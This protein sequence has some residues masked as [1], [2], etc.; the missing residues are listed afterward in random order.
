[1]ENE[2]FKESFEGEPT[3]LYGSIWELFCLRA[4]SEVLEALLT[5]WST[6]LCMHCFSELMRGSYVSRMVIITFQRAGTDT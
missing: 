5:V 4:Q 1:M 3:S 2:I 6:A